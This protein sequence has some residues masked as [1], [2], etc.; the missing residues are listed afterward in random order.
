MDCHGKGRRS[1]KRSTS[2]R[3]ARPGRS[4]D[5]AKE[6]AARTAARSVARAQNARRSPRFDGRHLIVQRAAD[7]GPAVGQLEGRPRR[8][9][10][11]R[12]ISVGSRGVP[13]S[14]QAEAPAGTVTRTS[15][16]EAS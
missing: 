6:I 14:N 9:I 5:M 15:Q 1:G 10:T 13:R 16:S 8:Q 12:Q 11:T 3:R 7:C 2:T 4:K